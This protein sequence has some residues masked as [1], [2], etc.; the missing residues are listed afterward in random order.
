MYVCCVTMSVS[1]VCVFCVCIVHMYAVCVHTLGRRCARAG[2]CARVLSVLT[3]QLAWKS[4]SLMPGPQTHPSNV[5]QVSLECPCPSDPQVP[6]TPLALA[7]HGCSRHLL[8]L[9]PLQSRHPPPEMPPE[10]ETDSILMGPAL[11]REPLWGHP[12]SCTGLC[13]GGDGGCHTHTGLC[14]HF[15][16]H[17]CNPHTAPGEGS[18]TQLLWWGN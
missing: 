17:N 7:V 12:A 6:I 16:Y 1:C 8:S 18:I 15:F 5:R 2:P 13:M 10:T 9:C 14:W 3:Q 4:P 11:S